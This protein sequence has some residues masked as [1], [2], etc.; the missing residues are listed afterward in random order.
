MAINLIIADDEYF[1]RQR[2]KK[3]IPWEKMD[4]TFAGEAE[5]GTQVIKLLRKTSA[6][7]LLLDIK[8]PRMDGIETARYISEHFPHVH[9]I[10]LSGYNDFEY[11]RSMLRFG[12]KEYL[13][14]PVSPEELE[15]VLS[16]CIHSVKHERSKEM[17]LNLYLEYEKTQALESVRNASSSW[18]DFCGAYP[19]FAGFR[20]SFFCAFFLESGSADLPA[21][22]AAGIRESGLLCCHWQDSDYI[23]FMQVFLCHE[24]EIKTADTVLNDCVRCQ[25]TYTYV[26]CGDPFPVTE[27]HAEPYRLCSAGLMNRYFRDKSAVERVSGALPHTD[28]REELRKQR[29]ALPPLLNSKDESRL[30]DYMDSLFALADEWKSPEFIRLTVTEIFTIYFIFSDVFKHNGGSINEV[31]SSLLDSEYSTA[32]L[33][34]DCLSYGL[35][36]IRES[37]LAPSDSLLCGRV[38]EYIRKNYAD[39]SLS[40]AKIAAHFQLHP[41]YLGSVFKKAEHSSLLQYISEVRIEEAKKLL[42][43]TDMKISEIA[44]SIGFS[45]IYYFSKRFKKIT[46]YTPKEYALKFS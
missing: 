40:V 24:N 44:E 20:Y 33:K 21:G 22:I 43:K 3:I 10:T 41:T 2:I 28:F 18:E 46:G 27:S 9:I 30:R 4:L 23:C 32:A 42:T 8:M 37:T 12:V 11:A 1:I 39:T 17:I 6:D 45:D 15:N 7:I 26:V 35:Q 13:L 34:E 38:I 31:V 36:C 5:N 16:R 14:K 29:K 25:D 19:E